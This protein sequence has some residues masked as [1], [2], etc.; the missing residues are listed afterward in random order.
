MIGQAKLV[1]PLILLVSTRFNT[2]NRN[3]IPCEPSYS[4]LTFTIYH[5]VTHSF[6]TSVRR[7]V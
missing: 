7:L 2:E 3:I 5:P 1:I 6:F 4:K